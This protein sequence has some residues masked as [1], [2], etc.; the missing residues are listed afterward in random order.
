VLAVEPGTIEYDEQSLGGKIA[1]LH[2]SG[3]D[4]WY[5]AHMSDYADLSNG[6]PVASGDVIGYC[7]NSGNAISTPPHVH[8]GHYLASGNSVNP[9]ADLVKWLRQAERRAGVLPAG[10]ADSLR[11]NV[12]DLTI[13]RRFGDDFIP[14]PSERLPEPEPVV[15]T[16]VLMASFLGSPDENIAF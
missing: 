3:G 15:L 1:R 5:Y 10:A 2:T 9:M 12:S 8:F 4:Y 14:E 11:E 7:G 6:D 13:L 16:R